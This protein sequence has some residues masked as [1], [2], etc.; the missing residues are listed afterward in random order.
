MKNKKFMKKKYYLEKNGIQILLPNE[1]DKPVIIWLKED[2]EIMKEVY[3]E[4]LMWALF[5]ENPPI[6]ELVKKLKKSGWN[7]FEYKEEVK[8]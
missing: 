5:R 8:R 7:K 3:M 4:V 6:K 1:L 2:K